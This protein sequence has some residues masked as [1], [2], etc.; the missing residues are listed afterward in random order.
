MATRTCPNCSTQYLAT[1]R[2]C[3]DCDVLLV[4]DLREPTASE[5]LDD[6]RVDESNDDGHGTIRMPL[7]GW[8]NQLKVTLDGMLERH[9]I[10]HVWEAGDLVVA[11][12]YRED[13][14]DLIAS[15]EGRDIS[16]DDPDRPADGTGSAADTD[17]SPA[18][19]SLEIEGLQQTEREH[20]DGLLIAAEIGHVWGEDGEL[21]IALHDEATVLDLIDATFAEDLG[22]DADDGVDTQRLLTDLFVAAD[23]LVRRTG[24]QRAENEYNQAVDAIG[25][26]A[27]PYGFDTT[28]WERL[29]ERARELRDD[30]SAR[31][32]EER[33]EQLGVLRE[34]LRDLV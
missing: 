10:P 26:S 20:L 11:E 4:D 1:V 24:E 18:E 28:A 22:D 13:L 14:K 3:I 7:T 25:D 23:R 30:T 34:Q 12:P 21:V 5:E 31:V 9:D 19:V 15:V 32:E 29:I 17:G 2:R 8:G 16:D 27:V 33:R 6:V